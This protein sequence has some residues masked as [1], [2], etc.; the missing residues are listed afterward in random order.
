MVIF[1]SNF[2]IPNSDFAV[3]YTLYY[4]LYLLPSNIRLMARTLNLI[5]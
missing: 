5:H 2:H 3:P 1:F 4:T